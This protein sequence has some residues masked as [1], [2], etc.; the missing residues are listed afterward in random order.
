MSLG[1][2]PNLLGQL[3]HHSPQTDGSFGIC[4]ANGSGVFV[5]KVRVFLTSSIYEFVLLQPIKDLL[6]SIPAEHRPTLDAT[7]SGQS[8][9]MIAG[10]PITSIGTTLLPFVLSD[11]DT[12][13]QL[14]IVLHA[15]VVPRLLMGMF[16][17]NSVDFLRLQAWSPK[18]VMFT[19]DFGQGGQR[20]V[21]GMLPNV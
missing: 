21:K 5:S 2:I 14:R 15:I 10:G 20:R 6:D 11:A 16:I 19:F 18:G 1:S 7:L 9:E 8:I 13:E 3:E 17:S 4:T 12:G